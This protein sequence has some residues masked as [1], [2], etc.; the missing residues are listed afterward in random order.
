M[1]VAP[2]GLRAMEGADLINHNEALF[3]WLNEVTVFVYHAYRDAGDFAGGASGKGSAVRGAF[4]EGSFG[5]EGGVMWSWG[6]RWLSRFRTATMY[7]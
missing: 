1:R 4:G 6:S 2:D 7:R 3:A 5:R